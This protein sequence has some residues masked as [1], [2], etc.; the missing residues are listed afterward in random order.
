MTIILTNIIILSIFNKKDG[1]F[2]CNKI[3]VF[4]LISIPK[5]RKCI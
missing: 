2:M 5:T 3:I 4:G 1:N